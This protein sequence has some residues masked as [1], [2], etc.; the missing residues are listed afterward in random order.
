MSTLIKRSDLSNW[1]GKETGVS[2]W[3][4]I[5]QA[6][7]NA[8]ADVTEDHQFIHIDA[9]RAKKE[10]PFGGTIA[11]GFL[12]LS[13]MPKLSE[14]TRLDIE[15]TEMAINYGCDSLRFLAPVPAGARIRLRS[16]LK[17]VEPK[18]STRLLMTT[19]LTYEIEGSDKPALKADWLSLLVLAP[20]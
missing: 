5:D 6:R 15:G 3:F 17:A 12:T 7:I 18:G 2:S 14:E 16:T 13:L 20:E 1:V 8:F 9:E 19:E 4:T 10:T 11:H